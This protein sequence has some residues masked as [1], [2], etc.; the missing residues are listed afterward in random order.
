LNRLAPL[1][2]AACL[3]KEQR[4][5]DR[6]HRK[7]LEEQNIDHSLA[8]A[9]WQ[10]L[11]DEFQSECR[12]VNGVA[13][14][15]IT[16][17]RTPLTLAVKDTKTGKLLLLSYQEAGPCISYQESGKSDSNIGFRAEHTSVPSLTLMNRGIPTFARDLA[18]S[19]VIGLS[20]F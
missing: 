11:C 14:E 19:L 9:L 3:V 4:A 1:S 18:V 2:G 12:S 20:R 17:E 5:E 7:E 15:R 10:N 13:G 8:T 16:I 6:D